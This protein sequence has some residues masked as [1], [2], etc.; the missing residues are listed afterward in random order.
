MGC[1]QGRAA[2]ESREAARNAQNRQCFN[3]RGLNISKGDG[4]T[5]LDWKETLLSW[6]TLSFCSKLEQ[7]NRGRGCA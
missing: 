6:K 4:E 7:E 5:T 1:A 3:H 2:A